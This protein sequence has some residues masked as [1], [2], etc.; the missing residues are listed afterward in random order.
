MEAV[1]EANEN[2][3]QTTNFEIPTE[4]LPI[5]SLAA[6]EDSKS[7]YEDEDTIILDDISSQELGRPIYSQSNG[8][9]KEHTH[10]SLPSSSK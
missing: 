4:M 6:I 2:V 5:T 7:T 10:N 9:K 8:T 3:T 1:S